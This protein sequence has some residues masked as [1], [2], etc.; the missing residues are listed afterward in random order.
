M[1][2]HSCSIVH[3]H[4]LPGAVHCDDLAGGVTAWRFGGR[5]HALATILLLAWEFFG[6]AVSGQSPFGGALAGGY[7]SL[8]SLLQN[9]DVRKELALSPQQLTKISELVRK[10]RDKHKPDLE[11]LRYE[12]PEGRDK[13]IELMKTISSEIIH[14]LDGV[15]TPTQVKRLKQ[16]RYQAQGLLA[17][18]DPEVEQ[19][20]GLTT[21]EKQKIEALSQEM[22]EELHEVLNSKSDFQDALKRIAEVRNQSL[23]KALSVLNQKQHAAWDDLIGK[24]FDLKYMTNLER[25]MSGVRSPGP[26]R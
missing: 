11:G 9:P 10:L 15:L 22:L 5:G 1:L 20:L 25:G 8:E 24:P 2:T 4:Q 12:G 6:G 14:Q 21:D 3:S 23:R 16:I 19:R 17:L 7:V 13:M 26:N 18:L